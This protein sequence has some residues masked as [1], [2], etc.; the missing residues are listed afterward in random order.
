MTVPG[1]AAR[2]AM[3][4]RSFAIQGSWNYRT[5]I[6]TGFAF[7]LMPALREIYRDRPEALRDA[8]ER[9]VQI[10]NSHPYLAGVALGAVARLEAEEVDPRVI[11]RFKAAVRGSLGAIGDQLV[12]A[13]WRPVSAL[14]GIAAFALGAPWW[15]GVI[16]FLV[17]YNTG[18]VVL[19]VW[20][21]RLGFRHGMAVGEQLRHRHIGALQ[22]QIARAG[23]FLLGL[24]LPLAV[25]GGLT[26]EPA[27]LPW[28]GAATAAALVGLRYGNIIRTPAILVLAGFALLG[29]VLGILQ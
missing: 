7:A 9:H 16:A 12:W 21:F 23:A 2:A 28:I 13:G 20:S 15:V 18:H 19:R 10:F 24:V 1:R 27:R 3:V 5:L 4:A 11:E 8:A 6:G 22:V 26:G 29:L 17:V 25:A 14:I